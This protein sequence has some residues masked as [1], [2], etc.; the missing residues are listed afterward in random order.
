MAALSD[1]S[2][3]SIPLQMSKSRLF[4][5]ERRRDAHSLS[6]A[7][8][9]W[10]GELLT[11]PGLEYGKSLLKKF[12]GMNL[13]AFVLPRAGWKETLDIGICMTA[14]VA[15]DDLFDAE[16]A[17]RPTAEQIIAVAMSASPGRTDSPFLR[18]WESVVERSAAAYGPY[19][20][21]F[22]R[23]G[24]SGWARVSDAKELRP[25]RIDDFQTY[26]TLR[27]TDFGIDLIPVSLE[28]ATGIELSDLRGD[29]HFEAFHQAVSNHAVLVNDLMSFRNEYYTGEQM[30][31]L[32]VLQRCE[33]MPIQEAADKVCREVAAAEDEFFSRA[34][35]LL[36]S[37]PGRRKELGRYIEDWRHVLGGHMAW[38]FS[39]TRYNGKDHV[40]DGSIPERITITPDRTIFSGAPVS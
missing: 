26:L 12:D 24:L 23:E 28:F 6:Q 5:A 9:A 37:H 15:L 35:S 39:S 29:S 19:W 3:F 21:R 38:E 7:H 22:V 18:L 8:D 1:S 36:E 33:G 14:V 17:S 27:R 40:W 34:S 10:Y 4:V 16:V 25:E 13:A 31:A 2:E 30:N 11:Q 32:F 20:E